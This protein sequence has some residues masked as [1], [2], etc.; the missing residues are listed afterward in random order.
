[1]K[2]SNREKEVLTL[3]AD[4]FTNKEIARE[5]YLSPSTIESHRKSLIRKMG[6]RN[7]A[8]LIRVGIEHHLIA[9]RQVQL[10]TS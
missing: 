3:I 9:I 6:V 8:G 1:M 2:I 7:T 5:L 4:E 10:A